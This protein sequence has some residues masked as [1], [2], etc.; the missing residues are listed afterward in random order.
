MAWTAPRTWATGEVVTAALMNTHVRD[1]QL[2]LKSALDTLEATTFPVIL[3]NQVSLSGVANSG[4]SETTLFSYTMPADTLDANDRVVRVFCS[5]ILAATA[6]N[7]QL[8]LYLGGTG[9]TELWDSGALVLNGEWVTIEAQITRVA[10]SSQ[11]S[12]LVALFARGAPG[13][14]QQALERT[15]STEDET[16]TLDIVLTGQ[17][18]V[19]SDEIT[20]YQM[21]VALAARVG[22]RRGRG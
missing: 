17:S 12:T 10:A 21:I 2:Y 13:A 4:T 22:P 5:L 18:S 20:A 14:D 15:T 19:G 3:D 8:R 16:G 1:N 7:K 11:Y 6:N 9:G